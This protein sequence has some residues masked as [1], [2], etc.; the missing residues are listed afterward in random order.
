MDDFS[1]DVQRCG[2]G[3]VCSLS[4]C[5]GNEDVKELY[6]AVLPFDNYHVVVMEC[7]KL[8]YIDSGGI[9]GII[10]LSRRIMSAHS[11]H[12]VLCNVSEGILGV[13]HTMK[14]DRVFPFHATLKSALEAERLV[15]RETASS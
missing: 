11:A 10:G 2:C 3:L 9:A 1:L 4:G 6:K 8:E 14:L 13:F 5:F 15:D 7:G 12:L